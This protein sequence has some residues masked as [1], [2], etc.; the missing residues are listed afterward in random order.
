MNVFHIRHSNSRVIVHET[1]CVTFYMCNNNNVIITLGIFYEFSKHVE[2][3]RYS[4]N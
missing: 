3:E 1:I 2:F 4:T